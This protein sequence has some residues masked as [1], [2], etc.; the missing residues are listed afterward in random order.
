M[1]EAVEGTIS[2][3]VKSAF[4]DP[5]D[6][7]YIEMAEKEKVVTGRARGIRINRNTYEP[8]VSHR[9]VM[10]IRFLLLILA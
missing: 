7:A 8:P 9:R 2:D 10:H 1:F 5:V 4:V 3:R 6:I